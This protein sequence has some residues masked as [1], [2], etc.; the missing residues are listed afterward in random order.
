MFR[1]I[2][3]CAD[4]PGIVAKV[5]CYIAARGA[6]IIEA[7]Q[8][9]DHESGVFFMRYEVM[10]AEGDSEE[11]FR[12]GFIAVAED[13]GMEW[14]LSS[15]LRKKRVA[16]MVSRH[17]HCLADLL[18]RWKFGDLPCDI[19]CVISNH[20]SLRELVEWNG[21]VFHHV[22]VPAETPGRECAFQQISK[23]LEEA[24]VDVVVLARY[25]QILPGWFCE[26]W[27]NRIINIHHSFLPSF[28][29]A[30]PYRQ[31]AERGVKLVGAT[32]HYVTA[33]LDG[34]PIIEQDVVRV[35]HNDCFTDIVRLGKDVEKLVLSRGLLYHLEDRVVVHRN[36]TI[37]FY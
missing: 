2:G 6:N 26:K 7:G 5:A 17:G 15:A 19:V 3:S 8:H 16:V 35:R 30:N 13:L 29:G 21:V 23:L 27:P 28:V 34:G 36:K 33:V 4:R 10:L 18:H 14:W 32:C 12:A 25:M 31:A 37:L 20:T 11:K 9:Q 24:D 1:L 22:L